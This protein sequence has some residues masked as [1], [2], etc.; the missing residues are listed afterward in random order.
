MDLREE[1]AKAG[2]MY[3]GHVTHASLNE[4]IKVIQDWFAHPERYTSEPAKSGLP[5]ISIIKKSV[6]SF[7]REEN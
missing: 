4:Q 5:G 7:V 1:L 6:M 2:S 3:D